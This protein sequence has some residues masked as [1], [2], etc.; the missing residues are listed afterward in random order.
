MVAVVQMVSHCGR[1]NY[2]KPCRKSDGGHNNIRGDTVFGTALV[3][4]LE[5]FLRYSKSR[6]A[7]LRS[8]TQL[9]ETQEIVP[10]GIRKIAPGEMS[11]S[12][13]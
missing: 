2:S 12:K 3:L 5:Q 6:K 4:A 13:I 1:R 7:E 9:A 11:L 10:E 8:D